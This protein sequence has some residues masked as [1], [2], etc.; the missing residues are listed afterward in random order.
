M[1]SIFYKDIFVEPVLMLRD[2]DELHI[3]EITYSKIYPTDTFDFKSSEVWIDLY[4]DIDR[5]CYLY[6][7][8]NIDI[9]TKKNKV[10]ESLYQS[11]YFKYVKENLD[12]KYYDMYEQIQ[13]NIVVVIEKM[14]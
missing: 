1:A 6:S 13:D 3:K 11:G 2:A 5:Q 4:Q 12:P 10:R 14:V 7:I 8:S 9:I